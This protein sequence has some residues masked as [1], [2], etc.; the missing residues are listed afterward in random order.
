[1]PAFYSLAEAMVSIPFSDG[2]PQSLFEAMACGT[3]AIL[4]RPPG[5]AEVVV[6]GEHALLAD[7]QPEP[8][9]AAI[10][11]VLKDAARAHRLAAAALQRVRQVAWLP[12][13][14]KR[15]EALYEALLERPRTKASLRG[16]LLDGSTLLF[17]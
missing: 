6:D 13:E 7:L 17:R 1:M 11:L 2:L 14:A 10:V 16:R 3:P 4:G 15:V 5:Y 8:L 12:D 9:A